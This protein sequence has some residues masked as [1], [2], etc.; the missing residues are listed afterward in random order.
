MSGYNLYRSI[1]GTI[2]MWRL[3]QQMYQY[4]NVF[5]LPHISSC[6]E[7]LEVI[8]IDCNQYALIASLAKDGIVRLWSS[9]GVLFNTI[10]HSSQIL[11]V[12]W[13]SSGMYILAAY[14]QGLSVWDSQGILIKDLQSRVVDKI[15]AGYWR[16]PTEFTVLAFS[17][18]W[19]WRQTEE[20]INIF[21]EKVSFI[22]WSPNKTFLAIIQDLQIGIYQDEYDIW[23]LS[24]NNTA[25]SFSSKDFVLVAGN[26]NGEIYLWDLENRI[27]MN[28]VQASI[29]KIH[30]I[31]M[32]KDDEFMAA[33]S[34]DEVQIWYLDNLSFTRKLKINSV[35]SEM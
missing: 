29:G 31:V 33:A 27:I 10:Q 28:K 32:R 22:K 6:Q 2:R 15:K 20:P 9:E 5:I 24:G 25:V 23:W 35:I 12:E 17:G 21:D 19:I 14:S 7:A 11:S 34:E 8:D 3:A 1:D 16:S 26:S 18:V 4:Y 30:R 13:D